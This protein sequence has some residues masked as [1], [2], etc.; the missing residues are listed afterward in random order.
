MK[1]INL[2]SKEIEHQNIITPHKLLSDYFQ[3]KMQSAINEA[4]TRAYKSYYLRLSHFE[5]LKQLDYR[6]ITQQITNKMATTLLKSYASIYVKRIIG[7]LKGSYKYAFELGEIEENPFLAITLPKAS[8]ERRTPLTALEIKILFN[9]YSDLTPKLQRVADIAQFQVRTGLAYCDLKRVRRKWL[10]QHQGQLFLIDKRKKTKTDFCIPLSSEVYNYLV[11][12]NFSVPIVSNQ[13]YNQY[14]KELASFQ[15]VNRKITSHDL[16][17]TYG[18]MQVNKGYSLESV[19]RMMG[20][21][22]IHTTLTHYAKLSKERVI[23]EVIA[24]R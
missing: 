21:E 23:N 5:K 7:F 12:V 22:K 17:V 9:N 2:F 18:Q 10:E 20:H 6:N 14:L 8:F 1:I 3:F 4:S 11:S 15:G 24:K 19:A 16:R 13:K